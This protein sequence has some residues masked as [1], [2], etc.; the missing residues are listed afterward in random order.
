M[1]KLV[2]LTLIAV[3]AFVGF[4][5][6]TAHA[7]PIVISEEVTFSGDVLDDTTGNPVQGAHISIG[8]VSGD[9]NLYGADF[10]DANGEF[11][12]Y[13]EEDPRDRYLVTITHPDYETYQEV[14][15]GSYLRALSRSF[16]IG[17]TGAN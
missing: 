13:C 5:N 10:T 12:V 8:P 3:T 1:K 9:P 2:A 15:S 17:A 6:L 14:L 4:V 16:S 11:V 7:G